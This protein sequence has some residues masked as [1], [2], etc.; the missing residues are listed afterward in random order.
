MTT[1][2]TW[3]T[4]E[5]AASAS[6]EFSY[7]TSAAEV[8]ASDTIYLEKEADKS[9]FYNLCMGSLVGLLSFCEDKKV[10][11]FFAAQGVRW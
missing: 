2:A 11:D 5:T 6:T 3:N 1:E 4:L 7:F 10:T 9:E 8:N